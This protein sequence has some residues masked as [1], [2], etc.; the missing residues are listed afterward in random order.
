M[1]IIKQLNWRYATKK[2]N[3]NKKLS[4]EQLDTLL[5]ATNLAAS[6][7]GL[8]P[9]HILVIEDKDIREQLRKAAYDQTQVTDASQVIVFAAKTKLSESDIDDFIALIAKTRNQSKD[10]FQEYAEMMKGSLEALSENEKTIWASKQAYIALGQLLTYCALEQI[11]AC[12][13]EGFNKIEFD[14]ILN[15]NEKNL[16]SV[17]MATVG[18]RADDDAYQNAAKVRRPIDEMVIRY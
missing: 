17:V 1:D 11:D 2:F 7:Y 3:S 18:Y 4:T 8:Q 9:F 6:S 13:M 12:P 14:K 10:A 16:T 15:L 5:E